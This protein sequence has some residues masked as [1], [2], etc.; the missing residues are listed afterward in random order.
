MNLVQVVELLRLLVMQGQQKEMVV[1]FHS[2]LVME[3]VMD[4][5]QGMLLLLQELELVEQQMV[6]SEL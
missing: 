4:S 1:V 2:L 6:S 3:E 5:R